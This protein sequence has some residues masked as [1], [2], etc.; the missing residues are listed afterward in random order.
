MTTERLTP[1]KELCSLF[2]TDDTSNVSRMRRLATIATLQLSNRTEAA[3]LY[4]G[5]EAAIHLFE[6]VPDDVGWHSR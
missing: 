3:R 6:N 2:H 4:A 5:L 1:L